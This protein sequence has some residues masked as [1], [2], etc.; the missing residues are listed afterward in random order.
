MTSAAES[1]IA[2]HVAELRQVFDAM[3]PS[4]L[5]DRDL[6]PKTA[7]YI[8]DSARELPRH[9]PLA[10]L[11]H[12]DR[13]AGSTDEEACL[14]DAIRRFFSGRGKA[15]RWRLKLLFRRGRASLLVGV[16]FLVCAF[17]VSQLIGHFLP[18]SQFG[19]LLRESVIIGGWVAMWRPL[20]IFLYDWWPIL[21]E[22]RLHDR[23]AAM[24]VRIEYHRDKPTRN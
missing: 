10:L 3:D 18:D 1:V 15:A 8:V 9:S 24:P 16:A 23:L 6:D 22:A 7:D 2:V 14:G 13:P 17:T 12:L 4:P 21:G 11:V 5:H 20:E 19:E